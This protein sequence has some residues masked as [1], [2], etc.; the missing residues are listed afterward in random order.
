MF[1]A[2]RVW[3]GLKVEGASERAGQ[4]D[5]VQPL[6]NDSVSLAFVLTT[7]AGSFVYFCLKE[8]AI[9]C[10]LNLLAQVIISY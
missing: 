2:A 7:N 6:R 4:A 10:L 8:P 5:V 9:K 3:A 1:S